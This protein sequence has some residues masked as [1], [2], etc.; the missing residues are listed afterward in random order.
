MKLIFIQDVKCSLIFIIGTLAWHCCSIVHIQH[1]LVDAGH[2]DDCPLT[3]SNH[4]QHPENVASLSAA[5]NLNVGFLQRS[6]RVKQGIIVK[7][8]VSLNLVRPRYGQAVRKL[9]LK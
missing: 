4:F 2:D 6:L 7:K 9:R 3:N 5:M 1:V 8:P